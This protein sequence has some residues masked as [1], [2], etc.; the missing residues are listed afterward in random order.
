M[1]EVKAAEE[2]RRRL[3]QEAETRK[4]KYQNRF[5]TDRT[6]GEDL[7]ESKTV[8]FLRTDL[9]T[10]IWEISLS[11]VA[12][13]YEVPYSKLKEAC[14]KNNIPL[15]TNKYWGDLSVGKTVERTPLP[16]STENNVIIEFK[17]R[18]KE[19]K[20]FQFMPNKTSDIPSPVSDT[21]PRRNSFG[22]NLYEREVL[23]K[24]VWEQ[25]VTKVAQK[26]G[27]SDVMIHKVCKSLDIPVPPRGYWAKKQ[28]G[29]FVEITPLPES[30]RKTIINGQKRITE[31]EPQ[32]IPVA[33]ETLAFLD[34][35][36]R[37]Q[38]IETAWN[39]RVINDGHKLHPILLKHKS[40]FTAW[41]K[42]NP[43]DEFA[44][45]NRDTYRR[46]PEGQPR[47]WDSVSEEILPRIYL[48]LDTLF[49]AIESLGGSINDNLSLQIRGEQVYFDVI[50]GKTK[51][52]HVLTKAEQKQLDKY[53][54]EKRRYGYAYE[55]KFRKNDY[56]PTGKLT[57]F[58]RRDSYLRDTETTGLEERV[59]EILIDLYIESESVR[60][61]REAKEA[62]QRKAEEEQRQKEMRRQLR[63]QEVDRLQSLENESE[64]YEKACRIRAYV[65][66]VEAKPELA[67]TKQEW[68]AWAKAKADWF[69][70]TVAS[71]DPIFGVRNHSENEE[72]KKPKKSNHRWW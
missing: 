46:I 47:L 26:Y 44:P 19:S 45:R 1:K 55:P 49:R 3:L 17:V 41:K 67:E 29:Q 37:G 61:E 58:S 27:V 15:P 25:P 39:L 66:A 31:S 72:S 38:V 65:A 11:R 6:G 14:E 35:D 34:P 71:N 36:E 43:R 59:G 62:A 18:A 10:E 2:Q 23:Y 63:D 9:Y 28:A 53:E 22:G 52:P 64:D 24:E 30:N 50:E 16:N 33:D 42:S 56:I 70:P 48:I 7:L 20:H 4:A 12:S 40:A 54:E 57:F 21:P 32:S 51:T 13:K 68:I 60:I 5:N 69:D 8:T